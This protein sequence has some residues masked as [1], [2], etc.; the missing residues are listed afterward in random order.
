MT[1]IIWHHAVC[2]G[3]TPV[4]PQPFSDEGERDAWLE[5][6]EA[7]TGHIVKAVTET[8]PGGMNDGERILTIP[9]EQR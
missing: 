9:V 3:C 8:W 1:A 7:A 6:H 5:E 4:L 2:T